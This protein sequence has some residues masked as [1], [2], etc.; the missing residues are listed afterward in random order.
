VLV[1]ILAFGAGVVLVLWTLLSAIRTVILPRGEITTLALLVFRPLGVLMRFLANR[2]SSFERRDRVM[3]LYGPTGLVILPGVWVAFILIGFTGIFYGL[4]RSLEDAFFVSGSSLLTLGFAAVDT[5]VERIVSFI[6]ATIG[7]GVVALLITFL[8]SIYSAF[9][10]R[11]TMVGLLEVRAGTPPSAV[12]FLARHQRIGWLEHMGDRWPVWEHWFV[13]IEESH[14]SHPVLVFFRSPQAHRSWLTA[15]GTILDAASLTNAA[16]RVER[17]PGA[18]LAIRGGYLALRR[19]CEFYDLAFDPD[20]RP[21]DPISV[22]EAEF[23]DALRELEEAGVPL[24]EDRAQAWRDFAG[25]RV[26]YDEPLLGLAELIMAPP[27]RWISD[28]S[29]PVHRTR[30]ISLRGWHR[31]P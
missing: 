12:E 9:S 25:W 24:K 30:R 21:D 17:Q 3:A 18:D 28:R 1:Q 20:P 31:S 15:A 16:V 29:A 22:T 13:D 10:R 19:I 26:N 7:L 5:T 8:P 6:E 4:G 11:E 2:S 14:L 27:A 23:H